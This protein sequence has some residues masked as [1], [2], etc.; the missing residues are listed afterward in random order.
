MKKKNNRTISLDIK[1]II[2]K[3]LDNLDI[4]NNKK[5]RV[6]KK[7]INLIENSRENSPNNNSQKK[8]I[9]KKILKKKKDNLDDLD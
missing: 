4:S 9:I 7:V 3:N 1:N 2:N 5:K 8:K 6:I